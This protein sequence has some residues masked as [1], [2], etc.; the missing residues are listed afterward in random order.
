[1]LD[2]SARHAQRCNAVPTPSGQ[3]TPQLPGI[4]ALSSVQQ[5][6]VGPARGPPELVPRERP[7]ASVLPTIPVALSRVVSVKRDVSSR[8]TQ[9]GTK[10]CQ[11]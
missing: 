11:F 3:R 7:Q 8:H 9:T 10:T 6:V 4:F 1:M 5:P 2:R